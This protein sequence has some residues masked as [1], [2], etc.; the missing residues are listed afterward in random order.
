METTDGYVFPL[1]IESGLA[2]IQS[3]WAPTADDLQQYPYVFFTSPDIW[4]ASG[5]S[6]GITPALLEET[7]Q[8]ADDSLLTDLCLMNLG[9]SPVSGTSL[10]CFLGFNPSRDW[11]LYIS[12]HL[13]KTIPTEVDLEIPLALF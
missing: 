3:I 7:H 8:E 9:S 6:H 2:Y 13:H 5:L 11:G 10:G 12:C 4:D 1:C